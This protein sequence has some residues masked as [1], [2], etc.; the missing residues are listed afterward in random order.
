MEI[1]PPRVWLVGARSKVLRLS[2]VMTET[3][4]VT[5]LSAPLERDV[6]LSLGVDHIWLEDDKPI[7]LRI[8][9]DPIPDLAAEGEKKK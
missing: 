5:G 6:R 8:R 2:E 4:D 7:K 3:V 1:D 9:V